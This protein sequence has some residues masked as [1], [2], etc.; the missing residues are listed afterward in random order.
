MNKNQIQHNITFIKD[1]VAE[2]VFNNLLKLINHNI[3]SDFMIK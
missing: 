1:D 2:L 3:Y